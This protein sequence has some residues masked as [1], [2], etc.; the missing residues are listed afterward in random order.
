MSAQGQGTLVPPGVS[1]ASITPPDPR[2]AHI[3]FPPPTSFLKLQRFRGFLVLFCFL[4]FFPTTLWALVGGVG[5]RPECH[6]KI[7]D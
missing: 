3:L 7:R 1:A 6:L 5:G 4:N 2:F